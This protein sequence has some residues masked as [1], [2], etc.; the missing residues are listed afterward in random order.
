MSPRARGAGS[1]E[2]IQRAQDGRPILSVALPTEIHEHRHE[3]PPALVTKH[4][5]M[6]VG[7]RAAEFLRILRAMAA[8]PRFAARVIRYGK[9]YRGCAPE[10]VIAYLRANPIAAAK[11]EETDDGLDHELLE[12]IGYEVRPQARRRP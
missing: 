9:S 8:D 3:A 4:N 5:C 10:D 2:Q 12:S 11:D 7:M 6:H 1:A